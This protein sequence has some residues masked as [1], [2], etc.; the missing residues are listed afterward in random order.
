METRTRSFDGKK[1]TWKKIPV[2]DLYFNTSE[3]YQKVK[4]K[5]Y[6]DVS[7]WVIADIKDGEE[8]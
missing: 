5:P 6:V 2:P 8:T 1:I 3:D 4:G 7:T